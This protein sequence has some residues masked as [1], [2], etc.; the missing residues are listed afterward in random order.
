MSKEAELLG[1]L[2]PA[3]PVVEQVR[4]KYNID[5]VSLGDVQLKEIIKY[6][7]EIDWQA[8]RKDIE[9]W[10]RNIPDLLPP[11]FAEKLEIIELGNKFPPEPVFAANG[12]TEWHKRDV[13]MIYAAFLK[14]YK[15]I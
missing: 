7:S 2:L 10:I 3:F 5:R 13:T 1:K 8:V 15:A 9:D 6:H 12:V 4:E 11:E 14:V